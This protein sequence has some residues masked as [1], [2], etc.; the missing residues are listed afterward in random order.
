MNNV[1]DYWEC[2]KCHKLVPLTFPRCMI[3]FD[4]E[5]NTNTEITGED[6]K[7]VHFEDLSRNN[8]QVSMSSGGNYRVYTNYKDDKAPCLHLTE[9]QANILISAL[10]DL[11]EDE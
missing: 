8:I 7:I 5:E 9:H 4:T 6:M 2:Y 11:M 1:T 3:C 10:K